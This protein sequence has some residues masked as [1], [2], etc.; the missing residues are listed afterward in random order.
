MRVGPALETLPVLAAEGSPPF[1]FTFID[2]DKANNPEYFAWALKLSR[3]GS[4][5]VVDNVVRDSAPM[6][7][8]ASLDAGVRGVR[9]LSAL[10]AATPI[11][12]AT[13]VQ[14]VGA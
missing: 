9:R 11:G 7:D 12:T 5:I 8:A 4:V 6:L 14:T 1:D 13:A 10:S 3:P 2:A